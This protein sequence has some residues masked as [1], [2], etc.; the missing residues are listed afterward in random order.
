MGL[1]N[2]HFVVDAPVPCFLTYLLVFWFFVLGWR[3]F[4]FFALLLQVLVCIVFSILEI[5][6]CILTCVGSLFSLILSL[7]L[8]LVE[9]VGQLVGE[10][11]ILE[12][13]ELGLEGHDFLL[14]GRRCPTFHCSQESHILLLLFA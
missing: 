3:L 4:P 13:F 8:I 12:L 11:E 14:V 9:L 5:V 10:L 1:C 6:S 7:V 2:V